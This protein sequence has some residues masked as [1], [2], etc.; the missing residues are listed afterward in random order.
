MKGRF[1]FTPCLTCPFMANLTVK[2]IKS[3]K[4]FFSQFG[5]VSDRE[6]T[7][8]ELYFYQ[9]AFILLL[10]KSDALYVVLVTVHQTC[11]VTYSLSPCRCRRS[12]LKFR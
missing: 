10:S 4:S 9:I 7:L 6:G 12:L 5:L 8:E 11:H 2:V 1:C 3:V